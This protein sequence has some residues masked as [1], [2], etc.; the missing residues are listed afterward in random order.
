MPILAKTY[1]VRPTQLPFGW[2]KYW[3][4]GVPEYEPVPFDIDEIGYTD[5]DGKTFWIA[6]TNDQIDEMVGRLG[7]FALWSPMLSVGLR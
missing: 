1:Y 6:Y 3:P 4:E 2:G 7:F 5:K